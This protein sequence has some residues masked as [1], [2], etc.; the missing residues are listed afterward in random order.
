MNKLILL[1]LAAAMAAC[2]KADPNDSVDSLLANPSRL[3]K[4]Q[5]QCKLDRVR[6]GDAL[7][8]RVAD[9]TNKRFFGNGS[10]PYTPQK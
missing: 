1:I 10:E 5:Q 4:L 2:G 8:N 6:V 7:C 3:K 9:A